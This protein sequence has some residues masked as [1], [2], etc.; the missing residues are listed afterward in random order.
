MERWAHQYDELSHEWSMLVGTRL[1]TDPE[2]W[3]RR[4]REL[5][6]EHQELVNSGLWVSGPEDLLSVIGR[7]GDELIHSAVIAWLMTPTARHGHGSRILDAM[8]RFAWPDDPRPT[9]PVV[10][11]RE[12]PME[13]VITG[14][15]ARADIVVNIGDSILVIENKVW[16]V[17]GPRQCERLYRTWVDEATDVRWLLLSPHGRPPRTTETPE[18]LEAWGCLS[19]PILAGFVAEALRLSAGA[20]GSIGRQTA[21]QYLTTLV[22]TFGPPAGKSPVMEGLP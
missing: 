19:Y 12:V 18:A 8:V 14:D 15:Q 3:D 20:A 21:R 5:R 11:R 10:V 16:A 17:E 6:G 9:G 7:R 2:T 4:F 22:A 1:I 13:S